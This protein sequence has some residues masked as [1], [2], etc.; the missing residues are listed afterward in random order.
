MDLG[1]LF[2]FMGTWVLLIWAVLKDGDV[3]YYVDVASLVLVGGAT[4]T[5]MFLA[6]PLGM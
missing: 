2:G 1:I 4:G 3:S 5:V 6:Y